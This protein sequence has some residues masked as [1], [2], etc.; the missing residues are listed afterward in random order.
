MPKGGI[1]LFLDPEGEKLAP[2]PSQAEAIAEI[3]QIYDWSES[4]SLRVHGE[5]SQNV[6]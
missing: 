6:S 4:D 3:K 2:T 1:R 5:Y